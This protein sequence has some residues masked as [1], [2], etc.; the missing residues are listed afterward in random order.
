MRDVARFPSNGPGFEDYIQELFE[1]IDGW[2]S[3]RTR[4]SGDDGVDVIVISPDKKAYVIEAKNYEPIQNKIGNQVVR[5]VHG[6]ITYYQHEDFLINI[7]IQFAIIFASGHG[8]SV[9]IS[10]LYSEKAQDMA[11]RAD[12]R[13]WTLNELQIIANAAVEGQQLLEPLGLYSPPEPLTPHWRTVMLETPQTAIPTPQE[14][15]YPKSPD[16]SLVRFASVGL[17]GLIII[18]IAFSIIQRNQA[19]A[20]R[21]N[22]Y[23]E[24]QRLEAIKAEKTRKAE[25][26]RKIEKFIYFWDETYKVALAQNNVNAL[27]PYVLGKQKTGLIDRFTKRMTQ[28]CVLTIQERAPFTM[29]SVVFNPQQS[30][31]TAI[32]RNAAYVETCSDGS[33]KVLRDGEEIKV[34]YELKNIDGNWRICDSVTSGGEI[35]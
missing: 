10:E 20:E 24:S 25:E 32:T 16:F 28:G 29:W 22:A 1:D 33:E 23:I 21:E 34:T 14:P 2:T 19:I 17:V 8:E 3:I 26:T 31:S 7:P 35:K 30:A 6:G 18:W 27:L 4:G 15:D 13:L 11:R 5:S 9:D 12:V